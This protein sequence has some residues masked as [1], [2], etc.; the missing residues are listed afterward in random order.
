VISTFMLE[1]SRKSRKSDVSQMSLEKINF[2][3][4]LGILNFL[5]SFPTHQLV[6]GTS[7]ILFIV[8][9]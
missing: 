1:E 9:L 4:F 5:S 2:F 8:M 6:L 3:D 7:D